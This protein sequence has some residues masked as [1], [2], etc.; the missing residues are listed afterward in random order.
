MGDADGPCDGPCDVFI[1]SSSGKTADEAWGPSVGWYLAI[2]AWLDL[3]VIAFW[4]SFC[5]CYRSCS[6][7]RKYQRIKPMEE[8]NRYQSLSQPV[9]TPP[10]AVSS[11]GGI[12]LSKDDQT[13]PPYG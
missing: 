7:R 10:T 3:I 9:Y 1:G 12:S 2:L 8:P 11:S 6:K 5:C 13:P 4:G